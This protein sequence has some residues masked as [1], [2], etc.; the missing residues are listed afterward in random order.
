M[1]DK[2]L[3]RSGRALDLWGPTPG[4]LERNTKMIQ[5]VR[6]KQKEASERAKANRSN[7]VSRFSRIP[8]D[9]TESNDRRKRL[10]EVEAGI[11]RVGPI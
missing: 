7:G 11:E 8:L 5:W 9:A 6:D 1:P 10:E 3:D 4:E 2:R